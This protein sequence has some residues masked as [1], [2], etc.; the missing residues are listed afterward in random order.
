MTRRHRHSRESEFRTRLDAL[1]GSSLVDITNIVLDLEE[2]L[3]KATH[4]TEKVKAELEDKER[5]LQAA[6]SGLADAMKATTDLSDEVNDL[7]DLV[8]R[9]RS[10]P[11]LHYPE[12]PNPKPL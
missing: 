2:D 9:Y 7:K 8:A 10:L 12:P 3:E 5:E 1:A 11:I 6:L 4:E